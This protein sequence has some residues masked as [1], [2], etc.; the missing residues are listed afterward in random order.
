MSDKGVE[1][2]AAALTQVGRSRV[3]KY[4]ESDSPGKEEILNVPYGKYILNI[5]HL[6]YWSFIK[7]ITVNKEA[8]DIGKVRVVKN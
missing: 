3:F 1:F 4:D 7:E 8:R 6:N 2:A 5:Y